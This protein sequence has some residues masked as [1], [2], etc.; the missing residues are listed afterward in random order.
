MEERGLSGK[1]R[2]MMCEAGEGLAIIR[3]EKPVSLGLLP[4]SRGGKMIQVAEKSFENRLNDCCIF[5]LLSVIPAKAG[6]QNL[7]DPR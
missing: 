5:I 6:I 1:R 2:I 7:M 4:S 3:P